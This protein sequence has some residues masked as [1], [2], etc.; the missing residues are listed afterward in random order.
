MSRDERMNDN[1]RKTLKLIQ[2]QEMGGKEPGRREVR[3]T[4]KS[5]VELLDA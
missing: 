4:E 3:E 1:L 5:D 2:G